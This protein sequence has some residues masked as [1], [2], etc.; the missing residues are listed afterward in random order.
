MKG[1][2]KASEQAENLVIEHIKNID[3]YEYYGRKWKGKKFVNEDDD[4]DAYDLPY[5]NGVVAWWEK[6][7]MKK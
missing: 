3:D 4:I 7:Y 1:V 2:D 6:K 5:N